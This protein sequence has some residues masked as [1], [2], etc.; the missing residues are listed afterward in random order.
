LSAKLSLKIQTEPSEL[1]HIFAAVED[2]GEK[3]G[4]SP[5]LV[6][7]VNLALEELGLNIMNHGHDEGTHEIEINL[8]SEADALT[9][10]IK[11]D[12]KPFDP[13]RDAPEPD[14]DSPVGVRNPGGLGVHLVRTMMDELS[15][16]REQGK[17]H[18]TLVSRRGE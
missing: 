9:I 4:W 15:Y 5:D 18:V 13:L 3:E 7:R 6:F 1:N 16:R 10:E 14:L 12:G 17:N 2:L 8:T 11:D